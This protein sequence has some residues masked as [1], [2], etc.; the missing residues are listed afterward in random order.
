[1]H[2]AA[3]HRS[4]FRQNSIQSISL[5]RTQF[6]TSPRT[7]VLR[8]NTKNEWIRRIRKQFSNYS[9]KEKTEKSELII[10][11]ITSTSQARLDVII[12]IKSFISGV[13]EMAIF[14]ASPMRIVLI[15]IGNEKFCSYWVKRDSE[16]HHI[17]TS[18]LRI[19][20]FGTLNQNSAPT[21]AMMN[22]KFA[23]AYINLKFY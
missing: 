17:K 21:F 15:S 7:V 8:S 20:S 11:W 3:S 16:R 9:S 18:S 14:C 6:S 23:L 13:R 2:D 1:M 12:K 22:F 5:V 19:S 10:C 4:K